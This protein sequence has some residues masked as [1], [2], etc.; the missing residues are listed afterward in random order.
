M[1]N[2]E[3]RVYLQYA[4]LAVTGLYTLILLVLLGR[5]VAK[6]DRHIKVTDITGSCALV[7]LLVIVRSVLF[8][9]PGAF[10]GALA[11]TNP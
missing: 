5:R 7:Y 10:W 9:V 11:Q 8:T 2:A 3:I 1:G 6:G 4:Y